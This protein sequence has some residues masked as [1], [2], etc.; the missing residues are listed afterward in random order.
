M[1]ALPEKEAS[2]VVIRFIIIPEGYDRNGWKFFAQTISSWCKGVG[3]KSSQSSGNQVQGQKQ[4]VKNIEQKVPEVRV[5]EKQPPKASDISKLMGDW[6][7]AF[8]CEKEKVSDR[9]NLIQ[10]ELSK[11][12]ECNITLIPFQINRAAFFCQNLDKADY[13]S[14][15]LLLKSGVEVYLSRWVPEA[16]SIKSHRFFFPGGWI[17]IEGLPF[18]LWREEVFL[19]IAENFGG[20]IDS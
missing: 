12:L 17:S 15:N 3:G 10:L 5:I 13:L 20:L 14:G 9:W 8:V 19:K 1:A 4:V 11:W 16:N 6:K 18:Y 2:S 7:K